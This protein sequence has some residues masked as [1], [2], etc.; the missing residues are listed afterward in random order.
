MWIESRA[1]I[2]N[3]H[4]IVVCCTKDGVGILSVILRSSAVVAAYS[5]GVMPRY[6]VVSYVFGIIYSSGVIPR[7]D[8]VSYVS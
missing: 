6:D 3:V 8:V 7:C 2:N 4:S 1:H 5:S